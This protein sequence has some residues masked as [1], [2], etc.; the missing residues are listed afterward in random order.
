M[1]KVVSWVLSSKLI[2]LKE[3][4]LQF[5]ALGQKHRWQPWLCLG[6]CVGRVGVGGVLWDWALICGIQCSLQ[7]GS[8]RIELKSMT[9]IHCSVWYPSIVQYGEKP[10]TFNARSE[11]VLK[12][13]KSF[14][15][16]ATLRSI[17]AL[18][19]FLLC[20]ASMSYLYSVPENMLLKSYSF[21]TVQMWFSPCFLMN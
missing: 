19:C 1:S 17:L 4:E 3:G 6:V 5:I 16:T 15:C 2:E 12:V 21:S 20:I 10:H 8:V 18:N 9:H 14:S 7:V 13:E 11:T